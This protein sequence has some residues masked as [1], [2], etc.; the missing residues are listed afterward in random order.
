VFVGEGKKNGLLRHQVKV[1]RRSLH[2]V[3]KESLKGPCS[4]GCLLS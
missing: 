3:S 2:A 1:Y 4:V